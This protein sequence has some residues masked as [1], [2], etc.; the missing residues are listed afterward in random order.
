VTIGSASS[1]AGSPVSRPAIRPVGRPR[2][3]GLL[4]LAAG[5]LVVGAASLASTDAAAAGAF[6]PQ[7]PFAGALLVYL[8]A[9]GLAHLALVM[10]GSQADQMILPAVGLLGGLGLL[11]MERLPQDL[12]SR[13]IGETALTLADLQ[14]V[15]LVAAVVVASALAVGI[16]SDAWLR[17]YKYTWAAAGLLVLALTIVL[18]T[19]TGGARTSLRIGPLEGQP[20]ELLKIVLVV[21]FAG[22]MS[23]YRAVLAADSIGVGPFRFPPPA[24]LLPMAAMLVLALAIAVLARDLGAALLFYAVFLLLFAVATGRW[25]SVLLGTILFVVAFAV[26]SAVFPHVGTRVDIWLDPFGDPSGTGYQVVQAL[27]ALGRG[28]L[29]GTGLGAGLPEVTGG[30]PIPAVH[31]DFP[32]VV[33][34]EELGLAGVLAILGLYLVVIERGLRTASTAT[35]DFRALLAAGLTFIIAVQALIIAAGDIGL[36]PLTGVTLPLVAY[37]GSSILAT[38]IVVGLLLAIS[39]WRATR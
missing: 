2:E 39:G 36:I 16:R 30:P 37:G 7:P 1:S 32:F 4:L 19:E 21:F 10:S 17:R 28:G 9:L 20:A 29:L 22:Y 31:T 26:A 25:G 5:A 6:V 24:F 13:T 33:V 15:W 23:E 12:V 14:L 35:D 27:Y 8:G 18:A 11:I 38:G 3:L 34:A